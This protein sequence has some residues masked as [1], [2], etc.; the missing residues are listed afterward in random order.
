V[1]CFPK[2]KENP[3]YCQRDFTND[4]RKKHF[5]AVGPCLN[6]NH[7]TEMLRI[8]TPLFPALVWI[9]S[10]PQNPMIKGLVPSLWTHW[11]VVEPLGGGALWEE[12]RSFRSV[13]KSDNG[14]PATPLT[15]LALF[16]LH[17]LSVIHKKGLIPATSAFCTW[18]ERLHPQW[19]H[20]ISSGASRG[21]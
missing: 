19:Q 8:K 13:L 2:L 5:V 6:H 4:V 10:D 21:D 17:G 12:F 18:T 14:P 20:G 1:F 3:Y 7:H 11:E 15:V 16:L 9:W